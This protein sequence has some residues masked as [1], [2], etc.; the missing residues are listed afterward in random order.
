MSEDL[1]AVLVAHADWRDE[2]AV[3]RLTGREPIFVNRETDGAVFKGLMEGADHLLLMS[4]AAAFE[5]GVLRIHP[6]AETD[7]LVAEFRAVE[8]SNER[9]NEIMRLGQERIIDASLSLRHMANGE[10]RIMNLERIDG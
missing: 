1:V 6:R 5:L 4:H 3:V 10:I 7:A 2:G 8:T 9:K